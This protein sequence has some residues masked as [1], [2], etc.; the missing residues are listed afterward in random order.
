MCNCNRNLITFVSPV[1]K[2]IAIKN[3]IAIAL[4]L[5]TKVFLQRRML[6]LVSE[7]LRLAELGKNRLPLTKL[8]KRNCNRLHFKI[9]TTVIVP[10]YIL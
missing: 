7:G 5:T 9:K 1:N 2:I 4:H 6:L 10:D 3:V 8:R